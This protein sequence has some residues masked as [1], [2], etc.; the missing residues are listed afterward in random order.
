MVSWS[1]DYMLFDREFFREVYGSLRRKRRRMAFTGMGVF[2]AIFLLIV[3]MAAG[4]GL[5]NGVQNRFKSIRTNCLYFYPNHTTL[6]FKNFPEDRKIEF[7]YNDFVRIK[8]TFGREATVTCRTTSN[9]IK[10][11]YHNSVT[12]TCNFSAVDD[13]N[14][15]TRPLNLLAGRYVTADDTRNRNKVIILGKILKDDLFGLQEALG[16]SIRMDDSYYT[17]VGI[18]E[19]LKEGDASRYD[20]NLALIPQTVY[21]TVYNTQQ[22]SSIEIEAPDAATY[23]R[24]KTS[25]TAYLKDSKQ[26]AA[27]DRNA[28]TISDT[29]QE[30]AK[31]TSLFR[32]IRIFL[33]F[34]SI[35]MLVM[36]LM[37]VSNVTLITVNE[38]M[39]EI[40]IRKTVGSSP[41]HIMAMILSE[42]ILLTLFAG[43]A[44]LLLGLGFV[45]GV[46]LLMN[47]MHLNNEFFMHPSVHIELVLLSV[48]LL[49]IAGALSG[50]FPARRAALIKPIEVLRHE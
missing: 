42:A 19:S 18:F 6:P 7:V 20:D 35:G 8:N 4:E 12:T 16:K 30:F 32:N 14:E 23:D 24:L 29:R 41:F 15:V 50:L 38:R 36:G 40:G 11:L 25:V 5:E 21:N 26:V 31:Y 48:L 13:Q 28:I 3:L 46:S 39:K 45:H 49:I 34:V 17:I 47:R 2:G 9:Q 44:G 37:N 22:I 33:W 43:M 10:T 1:I 27:G